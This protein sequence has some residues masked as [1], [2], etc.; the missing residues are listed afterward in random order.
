MLKDKIGKTT[1]GD[2]TL[3]TEEGGI[4]VTMGLK[5][6][7]PYKKEVCQYGDNECW[8]EKGKCSEMG[9]LYVITCVTCNND[10]DTTE[11]D[12]PRLPGGVQ[13]PNYIGMTATSL[14]ARHID[15]RR[16]HKARNERNCLVKHEK[17]V[18]SNVP[19]KYTARYI[20]R[21]NG[22]L[23]LSL[24]EALLIEA[25]KPGTSLNDRKEHGRSTGIIRI[26][27]GIT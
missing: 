26:S 3:V 14:H 17:E 15:H 21:E 19:Q 6:T 1:N 5:A 20:G 8:I 24:K 12:N 18:H 27:S 13:T 4:P 7:D 10:I 11:R 25:Q 9:A 22:L 16:G 23:H 2:T